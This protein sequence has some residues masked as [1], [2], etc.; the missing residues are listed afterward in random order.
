M[1]YSDERTNEVRECSNNYCEKNDY[2]LE[3]RDVLTYES[4]ILVLIYRYII[5]IEYI[6]T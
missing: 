4:N 5:H 6:I 1:P 3:M 2:P